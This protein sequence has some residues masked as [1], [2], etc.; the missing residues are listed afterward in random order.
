LLL[1]TQL[2]A[3]VFVPVGRVAAAGDMAFS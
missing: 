1:L 3:L 2:G